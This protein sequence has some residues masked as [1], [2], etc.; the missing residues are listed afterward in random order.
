MAPEPGK[1]QRH[2]R[3]NQRHCGEDG[4]E[5]VGFRSHG[6]QMTN[7]QF[8]MPNFEFLEH[9]GFFI[10]LFAIDSSFIIRAPSFPA[11]AG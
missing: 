2:K 6:R 9:A 11:T 3:E 1:R 5:K 7:A 8:R 4:E 10:R